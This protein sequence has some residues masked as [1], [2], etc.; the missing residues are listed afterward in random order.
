M[1]AKMVGKLWQKW[2]NNGENDGK[3]MASDLRR[4]DGENDGENDGG[5]MVEQW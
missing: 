4:D 1:E 3:I 2:R 5:I